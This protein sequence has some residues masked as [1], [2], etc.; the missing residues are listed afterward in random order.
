V[1]AVH[2]RFA[3]AWVRV[4]KLRDLRAPCVGFGSREVVTILPRVQA[5]GRE[6]ENA[7]TMRLVRDLVKAVRGAGGGGRRS[8]TTGVSRQVSRVDEI[9]RAYDDAWSAVSIG[10]RIHGSGSLHQFD[11]LGVFRLLALVPE[12]TDLER[13]VGEA[14]GP[15]ATDISQEATDLR[16]TL[17]ALLDTNLNLAETARQLHYHYNTVRYRV[18]KLERTV[19]PFTE[20]PELRL[21]LRLALKIVDMRGQ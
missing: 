4:V 19:G 2:Q 9:P 1:Q 12:G 5:P 3:N 14:L 21:S 16:R 7:A 6:S 18:A 17:G 10:R 15:L 8:F 11:D 13:F 20:D